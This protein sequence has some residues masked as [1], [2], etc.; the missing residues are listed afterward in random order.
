MALDGR[1]LADQTDGVKSGAAAGV[2]AAE[3]VGEEGAP[4]SAEANAGSGDPFSLIQEVGGGAEIRGGG[5]R[6]NRAAKIG[7]EA[8]DLVH[9]EGVGRDDQFLFWV[10]AA[11]LEPLYIFVA[12]HVGILAINA[13]AG[14]VDGPSGRAGQKLGAA[15]GIGQHNSERAVVG[16]L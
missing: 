6:L 14:P 8:E 7:V 4:S 3:V 11:S 2:T 13:L 15:E 10:A 16:L 9:V 5:A 12:G 1:N